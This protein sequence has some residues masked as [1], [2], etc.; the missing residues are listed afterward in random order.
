MDLDYTTEKKGKAPKKDK[1]GKRDKKDTKCFN[2][3]K[4]G[5]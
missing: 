5:H 2:Y 1:K 3:S 4:K